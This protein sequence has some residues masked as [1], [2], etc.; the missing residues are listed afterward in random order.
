MQVILL[1]MHR[2]G[3]S[4][5]TKLLE[6]LGCYLG[7]DLEAHWER[8]DVIEL[9]DALLAQVGGNWQYADPRAV[10]ALADRTPAPLSTRLA[11]LVQDLDAHRPWAVKDPRMCV[12]LPAWQPHLRSAVYVVAYRH[13]RETAMSLQTRD[14][15]PIAVGCAL[16]E[17]HTASALHY[18]RD[19]PRVLVRYEDCLAAPMETAQRLARELG[20]LGVSGLS[21]GRE[22]EIRALVDPAQRHERV[23]PGSA[24]AVLS[25]NQ[26]ALA[27]PLDAGA[28]PV[29]PGVP[30]L[31]PQ[32]LTLLAAHAQLTSLQ[33]RHR[34]LS[35]S[36]NTQLSGLAEAHNTQLRQMIDEHNHALGLMA[37]QARALSEKD[38]HNQ[39]ELRRLA[40]ELETR[41]LPTDSHPHLW[42]VQQR[43]QE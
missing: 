15:L 41:T 26:I 23:E 38:S 1:G 22:A 37:E 5:L 29:A 30:F 12:T 20:D 13:P 31:S 2:T 16:W 39:Q 10:A 14:Q 11:G 24:D 36:V 8:P 7:A 34:Q 32:A 6:L 21:A 25:G 4:V 35:Q 27:K 42:T 3:T 18:T 33:F 28:F 19:A 17:L 43:P 9:N 40:Q